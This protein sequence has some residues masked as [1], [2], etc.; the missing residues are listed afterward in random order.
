[1]LDAM[2]HYRR[3]SAHS[4]LIAQRRHH[5]AGALA[6][7][8]LVALAPAA[9]AAP[10][11]PAQREPRIPPSEEPVINIDMHKDQLLA[12]H[13]GNYS[14]DMTLVIADA[15]AYVAKRSEE[16]KWP[17]VVLD[18]DETSLSNWENIKLNN[19]GFIKGGPCSEQADMAC[20]FDDW[21]EKGIAPAIEPTLKFFKSVRAKN[22]AV[23][24][25]TGRRDRQRKA[26]LWNMDREG[27]QGW[28]GLAT[29]PDGDSN[30]SIVPFKSG[31]R[32]KIAAA[33]YSIIA[34]IGDQQSDIAGGFAEC[35]F[36]LPNPFYF[37]K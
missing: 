13:A 17:A 28:A 15:G 11:C 23:F 26:T 14:A 7:V 19:F 6:V 2:I 12:Y 9:L 32:A 22:I 4:A 29:R 20:G 36:K 8:L 37:I 5:C 27:F 31:E 10:A 33:G 34:T 18:I 30:S 3:D 16:V 35:G 25:I 1:M 21:I 24:F